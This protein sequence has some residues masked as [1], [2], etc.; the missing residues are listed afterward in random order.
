M[1]VE[2]KSTYS[3]VFKYLRRIILIEIEQECVWECIAFYKKDS[4]SWSL[5]LSFLA[6]A[7]FDSFCFC[8]FFFAWYNFLV[9]IPLEIK[10]KYYE[11]VGLARL[12]LRC[13]GCFIRAGK[14]EVASKLFTTLPRSS[15]GEGQTVTAKKAHPAFDFFFCAAVFGGFRFWLLCRSEELWGRIK[16]FKVGLERIHSVRSMEM[17]ADIKVSTA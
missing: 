3:S 9:S 14:E 8:F 16:L 17:W 1:G 12:D 15:S 4:F 13:F 6:F 5:V 10:I 11:L 2:C 7:C